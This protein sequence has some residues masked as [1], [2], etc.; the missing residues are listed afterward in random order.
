VS[1]WTVPECSKAH[2]E[3]RPG[4]WVPLISCTDDFFCT[5]PL[6]MDDAMCKAECLHDFNSLAFSDTRARL[7]HADTSGCPS[8]VMLHRPPQTSHPAKTSLHRLPRNRRR[9]EWFQTIQE[10]HWISNFTKNAVTLT[11]CPWM[12]PW[13]KQNAFTTSTRSPSVTPGLVFNMQ[14]RVVAHRL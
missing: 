7:Q 12:M 4:C 1:W 3:V 13:V 2:I 10:H 8:P 5:Y 6:C 14:T 9:D 11:H